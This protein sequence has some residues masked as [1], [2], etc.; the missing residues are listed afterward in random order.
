MLIAINHITFEFGAHTI[1]K[2]A[3][4]HIM[5]NERI[6][7]I[8]VNGAGKSTLLRVINRE[9]SVSAGSIERAGDVSV[10]FFNQDLLSFES[11]DSILHVAMTAFERALKIEKK[12][13][14]LAVKMA[15]N[16]TEEIMLKY[17]DLQHEFEALDGYNLQ[18]KTEAMLEGLGFKTSDLSR[19]YSEF[20]GGWRM[21]VLLARMMLQGPEVLMLDEPT[22]HL[23]MPSI[24]WLERYLQKYKGTV[25]ITSHDRYFL[26]R[27]VTKIAEID[28]RKIQLYSGNYSFYE[29]E[30]ALRKE[31]QQRAYEN[32]QEYI[33][34]QE[35][36]IE[37]FR[38]KATKAAQAQSAMK[39]LEKLERIEEVGADPEKIKIRFNIGQ[40]PGKIIATLKNIG[41]HYGE[42][43]ILENTGAMIERGDR[44]ALIGANGMGKST[45][46]RIIAG[47]ET[48]EGENKPGHNVETSFYAQHQLE[49]LNL[50]ND[51]LTELQ[52]CGSGYLDQELRGLLG[53]FLFH[54]DDVFKKIKVL[55]GGEKAR[56]ALAKTIISK[57]NFLLLDEPTNHLDIQSVDRII[58]SLNQYNGTYVLVS[59]NRYFISKTA[60]KIWEIKDREIKVFNGGYDEWESWKKAQ[61]ENQQKKFSKTSSSQKNN[62]IPNKKKKHN[63]NAPKK[64]IDKEVKRQWQK[65]KKKFEELEKNLN[66]SKEEKTTL[67]AQL[68]SPDIYA[69]KEKF[70]DIEKRRAER[71]E[72]I[73]KLEQQYEAT[74]EKIMEL[75]EKL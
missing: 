53:C 65:Q 33:R 34:Q 50:K 43:V 31:Q 63:E 12:M 5:P 66:R 32:Q 1:L 49:S 58:E 70:L 61:E 9:Y 14:E 35:R 55:S 18:H 40:M 44:I 10:G 7:L 52:E 2:D 16:Y 13:E 21:R 64:A 54:G 26:D 19:P 45:L 11:N 75:E 28:Q 20:S 51:L 59:H 37:R 47:T 23:D 24:E 74:F 48:F 39:R 4:W 6:G 30:K 3:S 17:S 68:A 42:H 62:S 67:E 46:L 72:E 56:V 15:E 71:A 36:F 73:E 8:G 41:K 29:K 38:A 69:D 27:M 60:N 22:N 57:A 25:I